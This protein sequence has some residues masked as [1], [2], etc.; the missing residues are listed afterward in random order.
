MSTTP[1]KRLLQKRWWLLAA[2]PLATG[3]ALVVHILAHVS[4]GLALLGAALIVGALGVFSWRNLTPEARTI[5]ARRAL[6]GL[7]A[8][9][10]AT[11]CYDGSRWLV[12]TVFHDTFWPFDVFPVFGYAIV[13]SDVTRSTAAIIGTVY[14]YAN[15]LLFA[16]AYT[17]LFGPRGWW[18]GI[19]WALGLETL[20][21]SLY[22]GWL[23]P[24]AFAEFVSVSFVGHIVYGAVLGIGSQQLLFWQQ[25]RHDG[26]GQ[27]RVRPER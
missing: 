24:K 13:G 3:A 21:L 15:G 19:L 4:L 10:L 25:R 9:L 6:I 16:V 20:M 5:L 7:L 12:V 17:I 2:L 23:H 22:P 27:A 26:S 1:V 8:G 11:L 18:A 14:H